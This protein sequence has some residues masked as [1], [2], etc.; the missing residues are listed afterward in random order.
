MQLSEID[1]L[2]SLSRRLVREFGFMRNTVCGTALTLSAAHALVEIAA[3]EAMTAGQL[4]ESLLLEKSSVSRL[5]KK[6]VESG[7]VQETPDPRDGR[8]KLLNLTAKGHATLAAID[9]HSRQQVAGALRH[10]APEQAETVLQGIGLYADALSRARRQEVSIRPVRQGE[11]LAA[12]ADLFRAYAASLDVDLCFQGFAAELAGL[13]G[14]YAPPQGELFLARDAAGVAIGCAAFRPLQEEGIAEMKRLYVTPEGR[15]QG[16]GRFLAQAVIDGAA[17]AGYGEI[18]LD[19]LPSMEPAI[20]LYRS[21]GFEPMKSY[22]D[23]PVGGTVFL[24]RRLP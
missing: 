20:A 11:D 21:L 17:R 16:L 22:Y 8:T 19:T 24:R 23:T 1:S 7:E 13:P 12:I 9:D 5:L 6:L 2:R 14:K 3:S 10:L 4:C 15:G 18:C